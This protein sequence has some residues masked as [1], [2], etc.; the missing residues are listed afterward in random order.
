MDED[1]FNMPSH[2]GLLNKILQLQSLLQ[3][4]EAAVRYFNALNDEEK[5]L[6]RFMGISNSNRGSM[7]LHESTERNYQQLN[8]VVAGSIN[9]TLS[10][11][12]STQSRYNGGDSNEN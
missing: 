4:R 6:R 2:S 1:D 11:A 3:V 12:E 8:V 5:R 10:Q 7:N 9:Y